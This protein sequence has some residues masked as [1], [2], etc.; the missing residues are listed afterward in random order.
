MGKQFWSE[1]NSAPQDNG[2]D[3]GYQNFAERI[4]HQ[5]NA[6]NPYRETKVFNP[7]TGKED[8]RKP[9]NPYSMIEGGGINPSKMP[10]EILK[11][12]VG[13]AE[14]V[15]KA[16]IGSQQRL[17]QDYGYLMGLHNKS[18]RTLNEMNAV[19]R[20]EPYLDPRKP[21]AAPSAYHQRYDWTLNALRK[22]GVVD[23]DT[24]NKVKEQWKEEGG[25]NW[26]NLNQLTSSALK[27]PT[28]KPISLT[29]D[30]LYGTLSAQATVD[31][32]ARPYAIQSLLNAGYKPPTPKASSQ[33][34]PSKNQEEPV[35]LSEEIIKDNSNILSSFAQWKERSKNEV[36]VTPYPMRTK[37]N[38]IAIISKP[39]VEKELSWWKGAEAEYLLNKEL[40][41][42]EADTFGY[43]D[44]LKEKAQLAKDAANGKVLPQAAQSIVDAGHFVRGVPA[45]IGEFLSHPWDSLTENDKQHE[46][47]KQEIKRRERLLNSLEA[48]DTE[49]KYNPQASVQRDIG[50][51]NQFLINK[52]KL[53]EID[54][55][56]TAK[57]SFGSLLE[58]GL[59]KS[60]TLAGGLIGSAIL[61]G[62]GTVVGTALGAMVDAAIPNELG[63][64]PSINDV[65]VR[66][67]LSGSVEGLRQNKKTNDFWGT[68][69][70]A[71][72]LLSSG[73]LSTGELLLDMAATGKMASSV[74][75]GL[76]PTL[77]AVGKAAKELPMASYFAKAVPLIEKA[78]HLMGKPIA[79]IADTKAAQKVLPYAEKMF[80]GSSDAAINGAIHFGIAELMRTGEV[81]TPEDV[82]DAVV[83]GA[84]WASS[85]KVVHNSIMGAASKASHLL[86]KKK[87]DSYGK[88]SV[89]KEVMDRIEDT[90]RLKEI[91]TSGIET[92]ANQMRTADAIKK[93]SHVLS[94]AVAEPVQSLA[95][96]LRKEG[97]PLANYDGT[98][99]IG[100][101]VGGIL[102]GF[103]GVPMRMQIAKQANG[104][105]IMDKRG[106]PVME[107]VP[108]ASVAD[109]KK[110]MDEAAVHQYAKEVS[111]SIQKGTEEK[112]NRVGASI[113]HEQAKEQ[114]QGE[115]VTEQ[116]QAAEATSTASQAPPQQSE[117]VKGNL[118]VQ[119]ETIQHILNKARGIV[120]ANIAPQSR[121][122]IDSSMEDT[123]S[124]PNTGAVDNTISG[125]A[126]PANI[127]NVQEVKQEYS[128]QQEQADPL[129]QATGVTN[130]AKVQAP[131]MVQD[132]V[133]QDA[134]TVIANHLQQA[135]ADGV[136]V[137]PET[138]K[139][140]ADSTADT[141]A[142]LQAKGA[143]LS[144]LPSTTVDGDTKYGYFA[145]R[146]A[147]DA[148]A[149]ASVLALNLPDTLAMAS[150]KVGDSSI[151]P[152][153]G[154]HEYNHRL[155]YAIDNSL[156]DDTS[157]ISQA[158]LSALKDQET[159]AL[160]SLIQASPFVRSMFEAHTAKGMAEP[161][162]LEELSSLMFE[163][164]YAKNGNATDLLRHIAAL[165]KRSASAPDN[166]GHESI[167]DEGTGTDTANTGVQ[168][169][170]N[171]NPR[172]RF[173][174]L[175]G[176]IPNAVKQAIE[177]LQAYFEGAKASTALPQD[178]VQQAQ[179]F[180]DYYNAALSAVTKR[181]T[182]EAQQRLEQQLGQQQQVPQTLPSPEDY[183]ADDDIALQYS[184]S[185]FDELQENL[186]YALDLGNMADMRKIPS[187]LKDYF[188][189]RTVKEVYD[190]FTQKGGLFE[191]P[192]SFVDSFVSKRLEQLARAGK[193]L[194]A[195][196]AEEAKRFAVKTWVKFQG[197]EP[198]SMANVRIIA[199]GKIPEIIIDNN[200]T[201]IGGANTK[202]L[203]N[204]PVPAYEMKRANWT[205]F[206]KG[207]DTF[208]QALVDSGLD[209]T[210]MRSPLVQTL[211]TGKLH[212]V[213]SL[214]LETKPHGKMKEGKWEKGSVDK[215]T[216]ELRNPTPKFNI[217]EK[218]GRYNQIEEAKWDTDIYNALPTIATDMLQQGWFV[219]NHADKGAVALLDMRDYI[220][221]VQKVLASE[222]KM[223]VLD[224]IRA[225]DTMFLNYHISNAGQPFS[226]DK[227]KATIAGREINLLNY[228]T[229][230]GKYGTNNIVA[231]VNEAK[232][233][234]DFPEASDAKKLKDELMKV[235]EANPEVE[236]LMGE[237]TKRMAWKDQVAEHINN[238]VLKGYAFFPDDT[239]FTN[240]KY[241]DRF[242]DYVYGKVQSIIDS[243]MH[244]HID[245]SF[246]RLRIIDKYDSTTGTLKIG[247]ANEKYM[248]G[249]V[250]RN[251]FPL[252]REQFL[253]LPFVNDFVMDGKLNVSG[254]EDDGK[255]I[256]VR[257]FV[258][259]TKASA[260]VMAAFPNLAKVFDETVIDG[261]V[262][263]VNEDTQDL[264]TLLGGQEGKSNKTHSHS[265]LDNGAV[266]F[267]QAVHRYKLG[268]VEAELSKTM[269][270]YQE[271][272]AFMA[273]MKAANIQYI[274]PDSALKSNAQ[275]IPSKN[276]KTTNLYGKNVIMGPK[277]NVVGEWDG[278]KLKPME[279]FAQTGGYP[280]I[281]PDKEPF[282]SPKHPFVQALVSGHGLIK[283]PLT[284]TAGLQWMESIVPDTGKPQSGG[285][286][287]QLF[288][289]G[290]PLLNP[291]G[292][293]NLNPNP[294]L[295][296][297]LQENGYG[298]DNAYKLITDRIQRHAAQERDRL[299]AGYNEIISAA[300]NQAT[301]QPNGNAAF[302]LQ[303]LMESL[304]RKLED[305]SS[306]TL[307]QDSFDYNL[308]K[309][310]VNIAEDDTATVNVTALGP[311]L[312][313]SDTLIENAAGKY[314]IADRFSL[315]G[316][317]T[318][319]FDALAKVQDGV[320]KVKGRG[321]LPTLVPDIARGMVDT[322][323]AEYYLNKTLEGNPEVIDGKPFK[324]DVA[325]YLKLPDGTVDAEALQKLL[326]KQIDEKTGMFKNDSQGISVGYDLM[327][328]MNAKLGDKVIL[329]VIPMTDTSD[330]VPMI[331]TGV[332]NAKGSMTYNKE[333]MLKVQGRDHDID[334]ASIMLSDETWINEVGTD[335]F[336]LFH[337]LLT[338]NQAHK[339]WGKKM[340]I[341]AKEMA[342][343]PNKAEQTSFKQMYMPREVRKRGLM[344]PIQAFTH[345][346]T[347]AEHTKPAREY[348]AGILWDKYAKKA[349]K[350]LLPIDFMDRE[351][352][353]QQILHAMTNSYPESEMP[354]LSPLH[355]DYGNNARAFFGNKAID[356][357]AASANYGLIDRQKKAGQPDFEN[358]MDLYLK[359]IFQLSYGKE[360]AV[361]VFSNFP[362]KF[363]AKKFA[364][365]LFGTTDKNFYYDAQ[366]GYKQG[367]SVQSA[368]DKDFGSRTWFDKKGQIV[369]NA[370]ITLSVHEAALKGL[371]QTSSPVN[372]QAFKSALQSETADVIDNAFSQ[373]YEQQPPE[374]KQAYREMGRNVEAALAYSTTLY[375]ML[376]NAEKKANY[377]NV[378][379]FFAANKANTSSIHLSMI[380]KLINSDSKSGSLLN[381]LDNN[382][383][384]IYTKNNPLR[385]QLKDIQ[386]ANYVKS[387]ISGYGISLFVEPHPDTGFP[388]RQFITFQF[389]QQLTDIYEGYTNDAIKSKAG[390]YPSWN[391]VSID[392]NT[393]S[394]PLNKV[395]NYYE[396]TNYQRVNPLLTH[397]LGWLKLYADMYNN[398]N[399]K[400]SSSHA[401]NSV[402]EGLLAQPVNDNKNNI[403]PVIAPLNFSN[404][405]KQSIF[406]D[407][408]E[409]VILQQSADSG[410][411]PAE[412]AGNLLMMPLPSSPIRNYLKS[413]HKEDFEAYLHKIDSII[414]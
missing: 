218:T 401:L 212:T 76:A 167:K 385:I 38:K 50:N 408:L 394:L 7:A 42:R 258:L 309:R 72:V 400:A 54:L 338:H 405:E 249:V 317:D 292:I 286:P 10:I 28:G 139:Q 296:A 177:P 399:P 189:L 164:I 358:D 130:S 289:K 383:Q 300:S 367:R 195:G 170:S 151:L 25:E 330:C 261:G 336:D 391:D 329:T 104:M 159:Q 407:I 310:A 287:A 62:P 228:I 131:S 108:Y 238:N 277:G 125:G 214:T 30:D 15:G 117:Q 233:A 110:A 137:T 327:K 250:G 119:E 268:M 95:E 294:S 237:E 392:G 227:T 390:K 198:A 111:A 378:F 231:T 389:P 230:K 58:Y 293:S 272:Q 156:I 271:L 180:Q 274:V 395:F 204:K 398:A 299:W 128:T 100:D 280:A 87:L 374:T 208:G 332:S 47:I 291:N 65:S 360:G 270:I 16:P 40:K 403:L 380:G 115:Q 14:T 322:K 345:P 333:L 349:E 202:S 308:L 371:G 307:E 85:E 126:V 63:I 19:Q 57:D 203:I 377:K 99:F 175:V 169:E 350:G 255:N 83:N 176:R 172:G 365:E 273:L 60:G 59:G 97:N 98:A 379:D 39:A 364:E 243:F 279:D 86:G 303:R 412:L 75:E 102:F 384:A 114:I 74:T 103:F 413:M 211:K 106:Q 88:S 393:L 96:N 185:E 411:N 278:S 187:F 134:I 341:D 281:M 109:V 121:S 149:L 143:N 183:Q 66:E 199:E 264:L 155:R 206:I 282:G 311:L 347:N 259:N 354:V 319:L 37:D 133:I 305:L 150:R 122:N 414:I 396:G 366:K 52:E 192:S 351:R 223:K 158:D 201:F 56:E 79:A 27:D 375:R 26:Y 161:E 253:D 397:K 146:K 306:A 256:F 346:F 335:T 32:I 288:Y 90:A 127:P 29:D 316:K 160:Q 140:Y 409:G 267:K 196:E 193:E 8:L 340:L 325:D 145:S 298:G 247:K 225:F 1:N 217:D 373:L 376:D 107:P 35:K 80:A 205:E 2:L 381:S 245:P 191:K 320:G 326:Y 168:G 116:E 359:Q 6:F 41:R 406:V 182:G 260:K 92:L 357:A 147:G 46:S 321:A 356:M 174:K 51:P 242:N 297:T 387:D 81:K 361:D 331:I 312:L 263:N 222:N 53:N 216:G 275:Y 226:Y 49:G 55:R 410:V 265:R 251:S 236:L 363:D 124:V 246:D 352:G 285:L 304:E 318:R 302:A 44:L 129:R 252:S 276:P 34:A 91:E 328:K 382:K 207:L 73:I 266:N 71:E 82:I 152:Q 154:F 369:T 334:K 348:M 210:M 94:S 221:N 77:S 84:V 22:A 136:E 68:D 31:A 9:F 18:N 194:S 240:A 355:Y 220:G 215:E 165:D 135:K 257:G 43:Q 21:S 33:T 324:L 213:G 244:I 144:I 404:D 153:K 342:D 13:A 20:L 200:P 283:V 166:K 295:E 12:H 69:N 142:F 105:P 370:R 315:Q 113:K 36:D 118:N 224:A 157:V 132:A 45:A 209:A 284:G 235:P 372:S 188:G 344:H 186:D 181:E 148:D 368:S 17:E 343:K 337:E 184:S 163:N 120:D 112:L 93:G 229:Y 234:K 388:D 339:A 232:I 402:I 190:A 179:V 178:I 89:S 162:A 123:P 241:A 314:S 290:H 64:V 101:L 4:N 141:I 171:Q 48:S 269:P 219:W 301:L 197:F 323:R 24:Y 173:E 239:I 362:Y 254:L 353:V 78:S 262:I 23:K 386:N 138:I 3:K 248:R 11:A 313:L 61:P 5:Q 67:G 70:P